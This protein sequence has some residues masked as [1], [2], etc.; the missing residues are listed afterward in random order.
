QK[1]LE[2]YHDTKLNNNVSYDLDVVEPKTIQKALFESIL[3]IGNN[4]IVENENSGVEFLYKISTNSLKS[5][6][7][8]LAKTIAK[9]IGSAD[10]Y[11]YI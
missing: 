6:P 8:E 4:E 7:H 5:E 1:R 11:Y 9:I 10:G 2:T 3:K